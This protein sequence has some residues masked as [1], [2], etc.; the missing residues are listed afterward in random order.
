MTLPEKIARLLAERG[1][2]Q[3]TFARQ[4]G[5]NRITVRQIMNRPDKRLRNQTIKQCADALGLSVNDLVDLPLEKLL[6][7]VRR[8][9][10]KGA[11]VDARLSALAAEQPELQAW[12]ERHPERA[13]TMTRAEIDELASLQ[14]T[15]GPLTQFGVEHFVK[16]LER[17]RELKRRLEVIAGTEYLDLVE[18][19]VG[20][21]YDKIRPYADRK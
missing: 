19:L 17:K 6:R 7:H 15:G 11:G 9:D 1:W 4:A 18:Q 3:E 10:G 5:L 13:A 21:V 2:N 8:G 14:G 16:L 12:L 20:L